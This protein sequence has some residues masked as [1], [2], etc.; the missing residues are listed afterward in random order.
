MRRV[1]LL[2]WVKA[3]TGL[4][5][6][7]LIGTVLALLFQLHVVVECRSVMSAFAGNDPVMLII[8]RMPSL[9]IIAVSL[10]SDTEIYALCE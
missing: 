8:C 5:Y 4:L 1:D 3:T 10:P 9:C 6:R 7:K 2:R